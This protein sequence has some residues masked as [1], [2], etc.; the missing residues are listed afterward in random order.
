[1]TAVIDPE[2]FL[3]DVLTS[4]DDTTR[5]VYADWLE[6][7]GDLARADLIRAQCALATMRAWDRAAIE[8]T[9]R[10]EAILAEHGARFRAELPALPGVEW[11]DF[12][13]GFPSTVKVDS[14]ATLYR[15]ADEIGKAAPVYRAHLAT[16]DESADPYVPGCVPWLRALRITSPQEAHANPESSLLQ[17]V[18]ELE[19][20]DVEEY[21]ML[22]WLTGRDKV[23]PL[24]KL[25][26]QGGHV[27]GRQ[28]VEELAKASWAK[29]LTSLGIGTSFIDYDSG[30]FTDPTLGAAG[31]AALATFAALEQLDVSRQRIRDEGLATMLDKLPHLREL[32]AR[33]AEATMLTSLGQGAPLLR[34]DL[35]LNQIGDAG[36]QAI[37]ASPRAAAVESLSLDTCEIS[38]AGIVA[39]A[40]APLWSTLRILDLSRNPV[41]VEGARALSMAPRP[42]LLHTLVLADCDL[43]PEAI[44]TIAA[45][46]WL[47]QLLV[48][49]L[50]GNE[51]GAAAPALGT[52]AGGAL[53]VLRLASSQIADLGALAG[54][55]AQLV[56]LDL[57][58]NPLGDAGI[59]AL[60]ESPLVELQTLGLAGCNLS[61][62]GFRRICTAKLPRLRS[63]VVHRNELFPRSLAF[64]LQESP[65][66]EQLEHLGMSYTNQAA[67]LA[68]E[69]ATSRRLGRLRT[70]ELRGVS[71]DEAQMLQ[72]ARAES[73][74]AVCQFKKTVGVWTFSPAAREEL[75]A[76]FGHAFWYGDEEDANE[77]AE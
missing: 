1:M 47:S 19:I 61:G 40:A 23:G 18:R 26:V 39:L 63:L 21:H 29:A 13:R 70:L 43:P 51:I 59:A 44:A 14:V 50:S 75:F 45:I 31:G 9:W 10:V 69:L 25:R 12:E 32:D 38:A 52:L 65:L 17:A 11:I 77:D 30:Y 8:A 7:R 24:A 20:V 41:G 6:E 76:R 27:V 46:P 15:H 74:R 66:A 2:A 60:F 68:G 35:G 22:E 57:A 16:F 54:V 53:R 67:E 55:A 34:L 56:E 71:F 42:A 64:L 58:K 37:A 3:Q 49:D 48:L 36:A 62:E 4:D 28:F 72:L 5:L 73:L 33:A